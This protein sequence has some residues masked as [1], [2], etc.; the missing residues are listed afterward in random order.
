VLREVGQLILPVS[1]LSNTVLLQTILRHLSVIS[2]P[3]QPKTR[4]VFMFCLQKGFSG[5]LKC[6]HILNAPLFVD[7]AVTLFRRI[8]KPKLAVRVSTSPRIIT[9]IRNKQIEMS[10]T[11]NIHKVQNCTLQTFPEQTLPHLQC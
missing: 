2:S 3:K 7:S 8:L 11:F 6:L 10:V 9:D 1:I 4:A 5:R